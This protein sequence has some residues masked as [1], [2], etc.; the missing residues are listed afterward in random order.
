MPEETID[1]ETAPKTTASDWADAEVLIPVD[2]ETFK[3][4]EA[5]L[6]RRRET[7]RPR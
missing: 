7:V 4:I 5:L 1:Y 6:A 3:E 2:R